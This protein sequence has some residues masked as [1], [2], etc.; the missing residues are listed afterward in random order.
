M[1]TRRATATVG[2]RESGQPPA[3]AVN[4]L[5]VSLRTLGWILAIGG[6][7]GATAAFVLIVEKIELLQDASY[8][9]SCSINPILSCGSVMSTDQAA[10]FGFPNPLLGAAGFPIVATIGVALL[11]GATLPRWFWLGLHAGTLFGVGLVHWLIF[12]SLYR[13]GALCPYCMI[14]WVVTIAVFWYVTLHNLT[15]GYLPIPVRARR[16]VAALAKLH[17]AVLTAW[18]LIIVALTG[19]AFWTY[20]RTLP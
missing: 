11:A 17:T 7:I 5:P 12:Q 6:A 14:V 2:R 1:S 3:P 16:A 10:V 9:P 15:S 19:E 4:P 8:V 13:I 20:W 18:F